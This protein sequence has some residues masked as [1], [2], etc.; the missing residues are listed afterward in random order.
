MF[1]LPSRRT[2]LKAA[3]I[4][5][6]GLTA[7]AA[8]PATLHVGVVGLGAS[9]TS[10]L[11][12]LLRLDGVR[13]TAVCDPVEARVRSAQ[14]LVEKAGQPRPEG[15][16]RDASD[17]RRLCDRSELD[18]V[19]NATPWESHV[20]VSLAALRGGKHVATEVPAATTVDECWELVETSEKSDRHCAMLESACYN[21]ETLLILN[22]LRAG[23]FGEPLFA[24]GGR[25]H[26]LRAVQFD[27]APNGEPW[28]LDQSVKHN[29]NLDPT[30]PLGPI[31]WWM[32]INRGD[33][34]DFLVSMSSRSC[35]MHEFALKEFGASD[36]KAK[37]DFAQGDT[38]STLIRTEQ[39]HYISLYFDISTPR[40]RE[41][42][43]RFQGTKSCYS[44]MD[45]K[46]FIDGVSNRNEGPNWLHNPAFEPLEP[47]AKEY[48][49]ALWKSPADSGSAVDRGR[50]GY[51]ALYRLV[52]NLQ[53]GL[54]PDIDVYD[55]V[56]W[57]AISPLSEQSVAN[58]NR[59]VDIPDFTRGK[60]KHRPGIDPASIL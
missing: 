18:L 7:N 8:T 11:N 40:P 19:V 20:P 56:T 35:A 47:Y 52:K 22:M 43:M 37:L 39:G 15:Y 46:I 33:R 55:A 27:M 17:F 60:W 21:R 28:R 58:R 41:G 36:S 1:D 44:A 49:H 29:G 6:V 54:P 14:G 10:L 50:A 51:L 34:F 25:C 38:N 26:D 12:H 16:S 42:M 45:A 30:D 59:S 9:G 2:V 32:D 24:E 53:R 57:S 3:A 23:V 5:G 4:A 48:E 31:A 13:V